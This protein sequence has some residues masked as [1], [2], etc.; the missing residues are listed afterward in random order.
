MN[1]SLGGQVEAAFEGIMTSVMSSYSNG[2]IHGMM[3]QEMWVRGHEI[4]IGLLSDS[5]FGPSIMLGLGGIL[6]QVLE[7]VAFRVLPIGERQAKDMIGGIRG[8]KIL[9]GH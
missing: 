1:L 3:V 6:V 8:R 2:I 7:D 5:Q 4:I 9:Q